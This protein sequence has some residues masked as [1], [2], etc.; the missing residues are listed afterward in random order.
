MLLY[1]IVNDS[2]DLKCAIY[3]RD[4]LFMVYLMILFV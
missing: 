4:E 2:Y 3:F 1:I